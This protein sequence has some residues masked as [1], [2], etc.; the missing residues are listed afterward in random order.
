MLHDAN[1]GMILHFRRNGRIE[2]CDFHLSVSDHEGWGV[3]CHAVDQVAP[4][5]KE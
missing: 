5:L 2:H 4:W 1:S 3:V